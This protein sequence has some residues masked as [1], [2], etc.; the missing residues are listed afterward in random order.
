MGGRLVRQAPIVTPKS[1][2]LPSY[3]K[4]NWRLEVLGKRP[5]GYHELRTILQ[6]I[7]LHDTLHFEPTND[8]SISLEC[9]DKQIPTDERNLVVR[10]ALLFQAHHFIGRG[11][12]I[13]LEKRIPSMAGLGGGS[14]NA[15]VT[16]AALWHLWETESDKKAMSQMA[17]KLGADVPFFFIG[18]TALGE[19]TGTKVSPLS[20]C[21]RRYLLI[22]APSVGVSTSNAY[23]AMNSGA[24]T[25]SKL[26]SILSS[27]PEGQNFCEFEP[28]LAHKNLSNDF[29]SV[30]FDME[31]E[32]RRSRDAVLHAG[33]RNA[34]LA[35]SGSSVF[36]IFDDQQSRDLALGKIQ[37]EPGWRVFSCDTLSRQE[38]N[39]A[40]AVDEKS[41]LSF[42]N[43]DSDIGA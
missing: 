1:F 34:L 19:G 18:G 17:A 20:D 37:T 40:L 24:L 32:I 30:I 25:T 8:G 27:S 33:A 11:A 2:T 9:N 36:G 10:A 43:S 38:Y 12:R 29:E 31:P 22:V 7:S 5:D 35:G 4:I 39:R 6:T 21:V 13:K 15:A 26:D 14:S 23:A 42:F 41:L 3:A 28:S 16:L